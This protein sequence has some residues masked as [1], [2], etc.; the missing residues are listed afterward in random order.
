MWIDKQGVAAPLVFIGLQLVQVVAFI[1]PGEV[2]QIA[3]GYI[4][5]VF[6][7]S[8]YSCIGIGIGSVI[9]FIVAK[10]LGKP[11][12][13]SVFQKNHVKRFE[14][15]TERKSIR[16][17]FFF[18]FV[19]PGIPKDSLCYVAGITKIRL[20]PFLLLSM[21]G[22]LPGIIG[23]AYIGKAMSEKRWLIAGIIAGVA[24]VLFTLGYFLRKKI[25]AAVEAISKK[26]EP[27]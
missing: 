4:F 26:R 17:L 10:Y 9:S 20:L 11:F 6:F 8:L 15:F 22:R 18:L 1:I 13:V 27:L 14:Q 16:T 12:I 2:P 25:V 23:S 3:G 5:G 19:I 7:G 21:A 24:V